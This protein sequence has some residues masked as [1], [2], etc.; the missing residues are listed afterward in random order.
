MEMQRI[1]M[2]ITLLREEKAQRGS[3]LP[4]I[5]ALVGSPGLPPAAEMPR[6]MGVEASSK[7]NQI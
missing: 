2:V 5:E 1:E 6:T 3:R 4:A 7:N